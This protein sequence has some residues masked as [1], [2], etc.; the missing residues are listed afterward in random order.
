[1]TRGRPGATPLRRAP[2]VEWPLRLDL[3]VNPYGPSIRVQESIA[4]A[5]DLHLPTFERETAVRCSLATALGVPAEWLVLTCGIDEAHGAILNWRRGSGPMILF[6][7]SDISQEPRCRVSGFEF[8]TVPRSHRF[9]VEIDPAEAW[10]IPRSATALIMSPN[11]PT[12]TLLSPQDAVRL[13]RRCGIVVVD[14]RHGDYGGRSLV[15]LVREFDNL[16]VLQTLETWA[17]LTGFPFAYAIAPPDLAGQIARFRP[18]AG[19]PISSLIA[20][21]ATL[22]DLAYVRAAAHR[23]REEKARL[24]RTLRKLNL[25]RP[26]PSWANFSNTN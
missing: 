22:A 8:V 16:V 23:V 13:S 19:L 26:L 2:V 9:A 5:S 1:M 4:A 21:E 25:V 15:P 11:D 14:E 10:D 6:P 20:A 24:Y 12:G 3:L 17:G 18:R 7:P